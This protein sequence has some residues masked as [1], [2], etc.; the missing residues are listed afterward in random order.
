MTQVSFVNF[1]TKEYSQE[2][3][4]FSFA[5]NLDKCAGSFNALDDLSNKFCAPNKKEDL[6]LHLFEVIK[7]YKNIKN[8]NKTYIMQ[9]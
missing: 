3:H 4:Y 8:I 1:H 9:I 6:N 5:I 7:A 2:L